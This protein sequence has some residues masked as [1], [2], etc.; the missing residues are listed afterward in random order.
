MES[1][2]TMNIIDY[3]RGIFAIVLAGLSLLFN[4]SDVVKTTTDAVL[5]FVFFVVGTYIVFTILSIISTHI[6]EYTTS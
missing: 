3:R 1:T 4:Y 2:S 5:W 6:W